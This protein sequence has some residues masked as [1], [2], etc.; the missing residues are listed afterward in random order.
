MNVTRFEGEL[1]QLA[2]SNS[3]HVHNNFRV[4]YPDF[5][6]VLSSKTHAPAHRASSRYVRSIFFFSKK[7]K[8]FKIRFPRILNQEGHGTESAPTGSHTLLPLPSYQHVPK[9]VTISEI[10]NRN[11]KTFCKSELEKHGDY[12]VRAVTVI[13]NI[14]VRIGS[15]R[16]VKI[17][18]RY[19]GRWG[20]EARVVPIIAGLLLCKADC[21]EHEGGDDG[22]VLHRE[23]RIR[24]RCLDFF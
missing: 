21:G 2:S 11:M 17:K 9:I 6:K 8:A 3:L 14:I 10:Y 20:Q 1:S 22:E 16:S 15:I 4:V 23:R 7:R 18:S 13:P 5:V 19:G 12:T 24:R